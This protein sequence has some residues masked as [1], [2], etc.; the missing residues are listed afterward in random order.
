MAHKPFLDA[1]KESVKTEVGIP[2]VE[3]N[4]PVAEEAPEGD[5]GI[6]F[7]IEGVGLLNSG[8]LDGIRGAETGAVWNSKEDGS[9]RNGGREYVLSVPCK[10]HELESLVR[11]FFTRFEDRAGTEIRNTNRCSTHVHINARGMKINHLT[12][13]LGL[14]YAFEQDLIGW[15]GIDRSVNHFCLSSKESDSVAEAWTDFLENGN[16]PP[17]RRNIKYA[18]INVLPLWSFGSFEFRC[19]SA[20]NE[21]TRPIKWAKFL[22][23]MVNYVKERFENPMEIAFAL[24]EQGGQ[25]IFREICEAAGVPDFFDEVVGPDFNDNCIAGFRNAQPFVMGFDWNEW[26]PLIKREYIPNPFGQRQQRRPRSAFE[27]IRVRL[28][29][30][31]EDLDIWDDDEDEGNI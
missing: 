13:V 19:G 7:E 10:V 23:H 1:Y 4:R 25:E 12:S 2:N 18:A 27:G 5:I 15:C 17:G 26:I 9:L 16:I 28:R 31:D 20:A 14:W 29:D 24:S 11:D 6:E 30:P 21:P 8:H 3:M 22:Y